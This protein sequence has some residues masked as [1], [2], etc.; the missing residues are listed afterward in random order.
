[1]QVKFYTREG[2]W[3]LLGLHTPVIALGLLGASKQCTASAGLRG[4]VSKRV[5]S[6]VLGTGMLLTRLA[7]L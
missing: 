2:N 5:S 7:A 3:D 4:T 1:M 6:P